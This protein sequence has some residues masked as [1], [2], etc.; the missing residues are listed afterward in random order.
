MVSI[1][2]PSQNHASLWRRVPCFRSAFRDLYSR[3]S[4]HEVGTRASAIAYY[5]FTSLVPT[6]ALLITFGALLLPDLSRKHAEGSDAEQTTVALRS[7][8]AE[9]LPGE[10]MRIVENQLARL[11]ENPPISL[12]SIGLLIALYLAM[13]LFLGLMSSLNRIEGASETRPLWKVYAIGL[14]LTL[15]VT[16]VAILALLS[17]VLWPQIVNGLGLVG[18]LAWV[19]SALRTL[20]VASTLVVCFEMLFRVAPASTRRW[21]GISPGSVLGAAGFLLA[22][23]LFRFYVQNFGNYDRAYG[24]LGGVMVLLGWFWL[25]GYVTLAAAALNA[26]LRD[27]A[28]AAAN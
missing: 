22:A 28:A 5:A 6:L 7:L 18:S 23:F 14:G 12:M 4:E 3:L 16:T 19:A 1:T 17:V 11:Q 2:T 20:A 9:A 27:C 15:F 21:R 26:S 10:A 8:I 24:S 13:S 25:M